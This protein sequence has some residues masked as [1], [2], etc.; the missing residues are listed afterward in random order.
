M[1][2]EDHLVHVCLVERGDDVVDMA[3]E[4]HV[5]RELARSVSA[6][7]QRGRGGAMASVAEQRNE[8]LPAPRSV[9]SA[10]HKNDLARAMV[11]QSE[12]ALHRAGEGKHI[13]KL[14]L[15]HI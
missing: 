4:G 7:G 13:V 3:C 12:L 10:V 8:P 5:L 15:I 2:D 14:S 11:A 1:P 6:T 9:P